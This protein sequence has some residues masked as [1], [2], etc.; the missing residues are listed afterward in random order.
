MEW[1]ELRNTTKYPINIKGI[2]ICDKKNELIINKDI[3]V[4]DYV[5]LTGNKQEFESVYFQDNRVFNVDSMFTLNDSSDVFKIYL[6]NI[7]IDKAKF[8]EDI[9]NSN[10]SSLERIN[11]NKKFEKSNSYPAFKKTPLK[12]NSVKGLISDEVEVKLTEVYPFSRDEY[13]EL[14]VEKTVNENGTVLSN[15][16]LTDMDSSYTFDRKLYKKGDIIVLDKLSLSDDGDQVV[17]KRNGKIVDKFCYK[18]KYS[19]L[20]ENEINDLKELDEDIFSIFTYKDKDTT[21]SFNRN[22]YNNWEYTFFTKGALAYNVKDEDYA[23]NVKKQI[24]QGEDISISYKTT[25]KLKITTEIYDVGGIKRKTKESY[26]AGEGSIS[27]KSENLEM[28]RY[29]YHLKIER[30][31]NSDSKK[32]TFIIY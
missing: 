13:V 20:S 2:R 21:L 8:N 5:I 32:G 4:D 31:G 30:G 16:N 17:L 7:L 18:E 29:I 28:G 6:D 19:E 22:K 26:I 15:F 9:Y 11:L 14:Y 12:S 10:F 1:I 27:I 3:I 24:K 23:I 25:N